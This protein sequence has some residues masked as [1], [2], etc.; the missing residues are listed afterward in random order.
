MDPLAK[1]IKDAAYLEGEFILRSGK[2]S[3]Y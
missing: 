1:L 2:K 3:N